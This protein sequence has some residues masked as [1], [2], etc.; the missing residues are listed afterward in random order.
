MTLTDLCNMQL[1]CKD[2]NQMVISS[3]IWRKLR[4]ILLNDSASSSDAL[5]SLEE[6]REQAIRMCKRILQPEKN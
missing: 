6:C 1:V 5:V 3:G 2:W 4:N